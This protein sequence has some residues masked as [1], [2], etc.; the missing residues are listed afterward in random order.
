MTVL[1][2]LPLLKLCLLHLLSPEYSTFS[3]A[4]NFY[5]GDDLLMCVPDMM[6]GLYLMT[7]EGRAFVKLCA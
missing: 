2:R 5:A 4:L 6:Q 3:H 7:F 1:P